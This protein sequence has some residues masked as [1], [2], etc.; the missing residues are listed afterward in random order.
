MGR[1]PRERSESATYHVLNRGVDRQPIFFGD[2]DRV[3][4]GRLLRV[5]NE[6]FG[7]TV[8]AYCLMTNHY[9]LML[10][11]PHHQLSDAMQTFGCSYVRHT[12]DR[13]GRD[14]PMFRGR[15]QSIPITTESYFVWLSR[16][17]H[18][19]PLDIP[20]VRHLVD[21]RW[22]SYRTYLGYRRAPSFLDCIPVLKRFAGSAE[23]LIDFTESDQEVPS[24][25]ARADD[26]VDFV[27]LAIA[28]EAM[29]E[30]GS[31]PPRSDRTLLALLAASDLTA[32]QQPRTRAEEAAI[33]RARRR[34]DA[35]P[36]I[37]RM[38]DTIQTFHDP[39]C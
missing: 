27:N 38:F 35:D 29:S 16:Y 31:I 24:Q 19:N 12:N 33:Q 30:G 5:I 39:A 25:L 15:F 9:H 21:Y 4:F 20:T 36:S 26:W 22:S 17:I 10:S 23:R 34:L 32:R 8:Y 28:T 37:R 2:A 18:R 3:E 7:I 1:K 6:K 11:D 13:I 14:G